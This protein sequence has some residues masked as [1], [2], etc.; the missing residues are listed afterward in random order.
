MLPDAISIQ[1]MSN[2]KPPSIPLDH[3][4]FID[5]ATHNIQ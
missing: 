5:H 3:I 1:L 4:R 2:Q